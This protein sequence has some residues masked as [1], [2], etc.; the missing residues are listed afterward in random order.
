MTRDTAM[1]NTDDDLIIQQF[2]GNM[3][4]CSLDSISVKVSESCN[5]S[6]YPIPVLI[7]QRQPKLCQPDRV[8]TRVT[9]NHQSKKLSTA[10]QLPIVVNLNP[11]SIYNKK[12]SSKL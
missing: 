12:V 4:V 5:L 11:R 10:T 8:S 6:E 1:H 3:S 7:T 9:I 2:D